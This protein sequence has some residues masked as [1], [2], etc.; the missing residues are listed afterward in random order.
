MKDTL[1]IGVIDPEVLGTYGDTG[2]ALVLAYRARARGIPARVIHTHLDEAIPAD[3]DVYVMGGGEDT[4]QALAAEHLRHSTAFLRALGRGKPLLAIC[5]SLQ[6]LGRSYTDATGRTVDGAGV[7]DIATTPQGHRSIGEL[8]TQP[9]IP[10]LTRPLTGFEN[11]GGA[12]VLGP[13]AR[14]LGRVLSGHGNTE[15]PAGEAVDGACQGGVIATYMHGPVL[16]RNAELADLLLARA[17]GCAP[18]DL[19][20]VALPLVD[21]LHD[22]RVRA[23]GVTG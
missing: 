6:I 2:N 3:L 7:L 17:L 5:A 9:L 14:P 18:A 11:H 21:R 19:A 12:T 4:A 15:T 1:S 20:P 13:D 8:V 22:E 23:A 10:G 16:A